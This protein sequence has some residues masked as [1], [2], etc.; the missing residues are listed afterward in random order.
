MHA[1]I[2]E[3]DE[4]DMSMASLPDAFL[5]TEYLDTLVITVCICVNIFSMVNN[6]VPGYQNPSSD[7]CFNNPSGYYSC[8]Y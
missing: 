7:W 3:L 4:F 1:C 8:S 2:G 6:K 5:D